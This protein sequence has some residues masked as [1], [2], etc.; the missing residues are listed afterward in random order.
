ML[1]SFL[2]CCNFFQY[3]FQFIDPVLLFIRPDCR[4]DRIT[5]QY[6]GVGCLAVHF[7]IHNHIHNP[8]Q[9]TADFR[10]CLGLKS[11]LWHL[12]RLPSIA[13]WRYRSK[14]GR[15]V[16]NHPE[17]APTALTDPLRSF[18]YMDYLLRPFPTAS[19]VAL[20]APWLLSLIVLNGPYIPFKKPQIIH[21]GR[22]GR[23]LML[24]Y[25][26]GNRS[27]LPYSLKRKRHSRYGPLPESQKYPAGPHGFCSLPAW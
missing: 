1:F 15:S 23:S 26:L 14:P 4:Q 17:V 3:L 22:L 9:C 11:D 12:I 25:F 10:S 16:A 21:T 7:S 27:P 13:P 6:N 19:S 24:S 5:A 8:G 20:S 2:I 18:L